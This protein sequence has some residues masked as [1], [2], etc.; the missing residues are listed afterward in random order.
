MK[1]L[2]KLMPLVEMANLDQESTGLSNQNLII[3]TS[4]RQGSH[5]P[6]V[7]VFK[8][9]RVGRNQPNVVFSIDR[10]PQVLKNNGLQLSSKDIQEIKYFIWK[11]YST[12]INFWNSDFENVV[13]RKYINSIDPI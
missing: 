12:L 10:D 8:Q 6:R 3:Y 2:E 4:T 11:N 5:G 13:I 1:I 7:K 9:G